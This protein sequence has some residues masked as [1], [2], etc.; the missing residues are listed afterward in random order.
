M[1]FTSLFPLLDFD[2]MVCHVEPSV[3]DP[4]FFE[5]HRDLVGGFRHLL[6]LPGGDDPIRRIF[7]RS[8]QPESE[9]KVRPIQADQ[10]WG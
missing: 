2:V 4:F 5:H 1:H 9:A 6:P 8:K 7:L 10:T 3:S